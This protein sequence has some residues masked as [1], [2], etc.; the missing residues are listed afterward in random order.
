MRRFGFIPIVVLA[1]PISALTAQEPPTA[2]M[3]GRALCFK[4]EPLPTCRS[5]WIT[6]AGYV[7]GLAGIPHQDHHYATWELG[8]MANTSEQSAI[9]GTLYAGLQFGEGLRWGLKARYRRWL[10]NSLSI[11]VAPGILLSVAEKSSPGFTGHVGF[12]VDDRFAF[13]SQWD[14][15][16]NPW[17]WNGT[18]PVSRREVGW[19]GGVKLGSKPALYGVALEGVAL[20]AVIVTVVIAC[21]G[22]ACY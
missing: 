22:G 8:L 15:V 9:G 12:N 7:Y 3:E 11:D 14:V 13:V 16:T 2:A 6:E 18:R 4:G 5:F 1:L 20:L 17:H 21:S 10:A 19:Y